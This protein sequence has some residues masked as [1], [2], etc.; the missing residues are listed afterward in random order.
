MKIL[1][2]SGSSRSLSSNIQLLEALP[3]ELPKHDFLRFKIEELPLFT[4]D[5]DHHPWHPKIL[6]WRSAVASADGVLITTPEYIH[7]IPAALKNAFE[8]LT[9][10]GELNYK[11]VVAITFTPHAPRGKKAMQSLLW[12]LQALDARVV[13]QLELYQNEVEFNEEG[14]LI[15]NEEVNVLKGAIELLI[16]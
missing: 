14:R 15:T 1:T 5:A 10:S 4:A 2:I 11:P 9:S 3:F 12:S 7:N 16:S 13:V 8:W 6:E